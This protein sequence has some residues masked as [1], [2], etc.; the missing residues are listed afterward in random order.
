MGDCGSGTFAGVT[1]T[2]G[3]WAWSTACAGGGERG[4]RPGDGPGII[5]TGNACGCTGAGDMAEEDED[6]VPSGCVMGEVMGDG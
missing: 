3:D 5:Y 6:S 4:I 1:V 2:W